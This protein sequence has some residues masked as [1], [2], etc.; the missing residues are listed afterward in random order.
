MIGQGAHL[1]AEPIA[2]M[3]FGAEMNLCANT[4][5]GKEYFVFTGRLNYRWLDVLR[6]LEIQGNLK[7]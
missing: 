4:K 6:T 5:N 1:V 3:R 2:V 7:H